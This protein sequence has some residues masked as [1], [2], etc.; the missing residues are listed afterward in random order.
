MDRLYSNTNFYNAVK[1]GNIA[2]IES[3]LNTAKDRKFGRVDINWINE[4]DFGNTH[5][6]KAA[7]NKNHNLANELASFLLAKGADP[8]VYNWHG[9]TPL[10]Y[11]LHRKN[12]DLAQI[13]IDNGADPNK[14]SHYYDFGTVIISPL[15]WALISDYLTDEHKLE[16]VHFL[17]THGADPIIGYHMGNLRIIDIRK[18]NPEEPGISRETFHDRKEYLKKNEKFIVSPVTI[19]SDYW[20]NV[21][22]KLNNEMKIDYDDRTKQKIIRLIR[23]EASKLYTPAVQSTDSSVGEEGINPLTSNN[24]NLA[25]LSEHMEKGGRRKRRKTNT[26]IKTSKRIKTGKKRR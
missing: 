2:E 18:Y 6:I 26:K 14:F 1:N 23:L 17:L 24:Q 11:A 16:I 12:Y 19:V 25:D 13:L 4:K 22:E 9:K 7:Q 15:I 8:N 3:L 5:L 21:F 10:L 20:F